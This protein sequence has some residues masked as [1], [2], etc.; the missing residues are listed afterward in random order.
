MLGALENLLLPALR[1]T[2]GATQDLQGGPAT[3]PA[4]G[5]SRV[6]LHATRLRRPRTAP[7]S[8]TAPIRDPASLGWQGT[9]A[10]DAAHPLDFPLPTEAIGELAEVQSPPGRI[11]SAGDAYLLD[12]RT[13][14]FFRA[15][16]GLVVART[17]GARSAGYRERSEGRIDLELRVWAKDR[18]SIDTLLARSLQTVLS[19]FESINVIDL[20]DAAPGFGLRMTRLHLELKD[21]TRHFDAAA[22]TWLLGV[23]RCRLRGELELA[24]TL[25][26]PE[27]EGRIADVEIH[28][29][30]PSNAN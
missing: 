1:E 28:L 23:A 20:T 16:P 18:D 4:Q 2:L 13:L 17:R 5:D 15:A 3:A 24:L 9:L 12:G 6:A 11:L 21:I 7:D 14:R 26:A 10:S 25:G 19:A 8:D 29:H 30:G 22:P 27:E